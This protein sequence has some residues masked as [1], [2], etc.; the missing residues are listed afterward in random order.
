MN[1]YAVTERRLKD[2]QPAD[3]MILWLPVFLSCGIGVYYWLPSEP[4]ILWSIYGL[5]ASAGL[6][7]ATWQ[8]R[9]VPV[10]RWVV[11]IAVAFTLGMSLAQYQAQATKTVLL[12]QRIWNGSIIGTIHSFER[13]GQGWRIVL[14]NAAIENN[15]KSY[16]FRISMR[17][18]GFVPDVGGILKVRASLMPP[19]PPLVPGS[20]DFKRNAFFDGISGY[21]YVTKIIGYKKPEVT[22]KT[23]ILETYRDWLTEK[24]YAVLKQP[25]AGIVTAMLNGQ[26]AGIERKTTQ[27]LQQ[28]G[29]QHVISISGLH[30]GLMAITVFYVTRLLMAMIMTLALHWPIKKI[31]AGFALVS[32]VFY[33][34]I[35]GNSPPTLRSVL[36]SGIALIAIMLD[37]EPIQLRV[38]ALSGIL[39]LILQPDSLIDI[40]FQMSFAAVVGLVA[41]YQQTKQFWASAFWQ[42]SIVMKALRALAITV[43]TS[44]VATIITAP[45]VLLYFQQIPLLSMLANLLATPPITFMIMPGTFL[46]YLLTPVPLLG[47]WSIRLMGWGVSLMMDVGTFV[48]K[49][50]SAVF[51]MQALP[52]SAM[53]LI[54]LGVFSVIVVKH[55]MRWMG[56]IAVLLGVIIIPFQSHPDFLIMSSRV[57]LQ[58]DPESDV[59]FYEGRLGG[60]EK[61]MMLQWTGKKK[62]E[63]FPCAEEICEIHLK[64]RTIRL[65]RTVP[66]LKEACKGKADLILTNYYLDWRCGKTPVIDR[67]DLERIGGHAVFLKKSIRIEKAVF[68]KNRRKWQ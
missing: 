47:E 58:P 1:Q 51:K 4:S 34:L 53:V 6:A 52:L 61:N 10:W 16:T 49:L 22:H 12:S 63:P 45:L 18:K 15:P 42:S 32:I 26:R 8:W 14:Q 37:R 43:V 27:I 25:E 13:A 38:V 60:F 5:I 54:M 36:M 68:S 19:S 41:F 67:H 30:V 57:I 35:V 40:G 24:V 64:N 23:D 2:L 65:I 7:L 48:A 20:Y 59:L 21:G 31:A 29:L 17:Q 55:R 33:L 44:I 3:N 50:P 66:A 56:L 28:S 39:I 9:F 11:C 46:A 62:A